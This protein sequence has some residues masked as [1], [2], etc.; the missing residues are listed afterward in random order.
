MTFATLC[1]VGF[2]LFDAIRCRF[3]VG[4]WDPNDHMPPYDPGSLRD[5]FDELMD[6]W[7]NG[8]ENTPGCDWII[9]RAGDTPGRIVGDEYPFKESFNK[10][11]KFRRMQE[12]AKEADKE[13]K[14][15][16]E[17]KKEG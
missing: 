16:D 11:V 10:P 1:R 12:A 17:E 8:P 3:E 5:H 9:P 2:S 15:K 4:G 7:E 13:D 6:C 14:K